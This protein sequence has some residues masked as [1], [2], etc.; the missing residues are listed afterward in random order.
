MDNLI[1]LIASGDSVEASDAIKDA[2][3]KKA[4]ERIETIRP[5]VVSQMFDLENEVE[6]EEESDVGQEEE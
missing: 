5:A 3:M 4:M 2:L 6:S 1:D